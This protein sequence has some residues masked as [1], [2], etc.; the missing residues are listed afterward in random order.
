VSALPSRIAERLRAERAAE[1]KRAASDSTCPSCGA[2]VLAGLDEDVAAAPALAEPSPVAYLA[3]V[4]ACLSR[5]GVLALSGSPAA[6]KRGE[7]HRLDE[8]QLADGGPRLPLHLEHSC[9]AP[10]ATS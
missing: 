2:A 3:A 7:L 8:T 9:A 5:R 10:G 6:G 1:A 4:V